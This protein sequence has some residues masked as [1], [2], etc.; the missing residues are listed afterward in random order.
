[1][2]RLAG[3]TLESRWADWTRAE[4]TSDSRVPRLGLAKTEANGVRTVITRD[5]GRPG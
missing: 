5:L 3:M 1:M 2:A 4:F